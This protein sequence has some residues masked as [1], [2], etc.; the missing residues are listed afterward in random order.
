M[1]RKKKTSNIESEKEQ[2]ADDYIGYGEHKL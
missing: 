2:I 1:K